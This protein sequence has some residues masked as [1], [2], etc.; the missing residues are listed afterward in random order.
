MRALAKTITFAVL[1][2]AVGFG[3]AYALTGSVRIAGGIALIEPLVNTLVFYGHER[4]WAGRAGDGHACLASALQRGAAR[5][6][7]APV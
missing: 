2:V 3:V 4:V 1:H 5:S 6:R 7:P